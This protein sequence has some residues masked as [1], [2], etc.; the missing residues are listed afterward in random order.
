MMLQLKN[1]LDL[2]D[3]KVILW[4]QTIRSSYL[5]KTLSMLTHTGSGK[6]WIIFALGM[7]ALQV[8]GLFIMPMQNAF[9]ASL[10]ATIPAWLIGIV[11]KRVVAKERPCNTY[12][13]IKTPVCGSF[14]SNHTSASVALFVALLLRD[15]P[16]APFIGV[17]AFLISYSRIYLGVHYL[18]DVLGGMFLGISC[19]C[20]H[21]LLF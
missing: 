9:M 18:T 15:H 10:A 4:M 2:A 11:I 6:V 19:A 1:Q 5:D 14:P 13:L 3:Q 17:W 16:F 7:T 8:N 21:Y 12:N 20:L